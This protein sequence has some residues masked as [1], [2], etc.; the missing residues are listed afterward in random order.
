[1]P[2][3]KAVAKKPVAKSKTAPAKKASSGTPA[4]ARK[5]PAKV[6]EAPDETNLQTKAA[7]PRTRVKKTTAPKRAMKPKSAPPAPKETSSPVMYTNRQKNKQIQGVTFAQLSEMTGVGIG[8]E[9]FVVMVELLRGGDDRQAVNNR[10]KGLLPTKTAT[11]EL[12][13]V[14]NLVSGVLAMLRTKGFVVEG[15]WQVKVPSA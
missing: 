8:T 13:S 5:A 7:S 10:L 14:P 12:K 11:G 1:M 4:R 2:V 15:N 6:Q 3:K 9:K